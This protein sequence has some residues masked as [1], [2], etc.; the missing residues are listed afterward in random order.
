M[1]PNDRPLRIIACAGIAAFVLSAA[2]HAEVIVHDNSDGTFEWDFRYYNSG[3]GEWVEGNAL[4]ITQP[5]TQ[6][7]E[8]SPN[9]LYYFWYEAFTSCDLVTR[10]IG[11]LDDGVVRVASSG[12]EEV[13]QSCGQYFVTPIA[14]FESEE[15]VGP[16]ATYVESEPASV[17]SW[18]ASAIPFLGDHAYIGVRLEIDGA[19]HYGWIEVE[20]QPTPAYSAR[21][22]PQSWA[23]ETESDTPI[24]IPVPEIPGDLNSDG[25][26]N[27]ADLLQLLA[28]WGKCANDDECLADL[29]GDGSV[30][31]SDMLVLLTNWST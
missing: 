5:P 29:N 3:G 22:L 26:V 12:V 25:S 30:N 13:V 18:N 10:S 11:R 4:D 17:F 23:W 14:E 21:Y 6:S 8:Y 16:D 27:V 31:V 28:S 9:G 1:K 15:A 2:L 7:G 24:T 19:F 20:W